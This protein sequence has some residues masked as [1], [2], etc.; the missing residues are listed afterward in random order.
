MSAVPLA[1]LLLLGPA[2]EHLAPLALEWHAPAG[3]PQR[4]RVDDRLHELLP[5]LGE[6]VPIGAPAR[7][8]VSARI[9]LADGDRWALSLRFESERGV[10][11][12]RLSGPECVALADAAALVIAVGVDPLEVSQNLAQ[13]RRGEAA[14]EPATSP[15]PSKPAPRVEDPHDDAHEDSHAPLDAGREHDQI[16]ESPKLD[17]RPR[18]EIDARFSLALVG[19]GGYGPLQLAGAGV[20]LELGAF[21][22]WWRAAIRGLYLLPRTQRL[23]G[24]LAGRFDGFG[25][26]ARGCAVPWVGQVELPICAGLEA[27]SLRGRGTGSTPAPREAGVPWAAALIG[28]GLRWPVRDRL[29]LGLDLELLVPIT[30]GGFTIDG[31]V[32]SRLT[33]VGVR[34][35]AGLELRL[36]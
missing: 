11:E 16:D 27:G 7:V 1:A 32:V 31:A 21:G 12:R 35:F 28:P 20:G 6:L 13:G 19:G 2:P 26:A 3:C 29:A 34:A 23:A 8:S 14:P 9:D 36:P 33:P 15:K 22:P 4:E 17:Q 25:I 24:D 10:D 30:R 5:E 18:E